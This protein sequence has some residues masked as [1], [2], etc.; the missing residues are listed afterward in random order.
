[1]QVTGYSWLPCMIGA[2]QS[3]VLEKPHHSR[4]LPREQRPD[5]KAKFFP[6]AM[7]LKHC[8]LTK[9]NMVP[10]GKEKNT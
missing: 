7:S 4:N 10:P 3:Q 1:M 8:L 5:W 2:A 9:L 6:P